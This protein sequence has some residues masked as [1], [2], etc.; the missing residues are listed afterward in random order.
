[1]KLVDVDIKQAGYDEK[2]ATIKNIQFSINKGE[3]VGLIGP[4]GAGKSTTIK[5]ILGLID[6]QGNITFPSKGDYAYIPEQP[7]FYDKLTL[8][9]HLDLAAAVMSMNDEMFFERAIYLLK[10]FKMEEVKHQLPN[11]FSK[12]MQQKVMLLIAFLIKPEVYIV[13]EPFIGLD[14]K[15]TKD[16]LNII[17]KEKQLGAGVLMSTHVLGT[18]EKVCDRFLLM[19][20]G[21]LIAEGTLKTIQNQCQLPNGSLFDCY[22]FLAEDEDNDRT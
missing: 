2:L 14:P 10:R 16:F 15:A 1:M 5:S 19:K 8:W 9:E 6:M 17:H 20:D 21:K 18:A 11:T 13:D 7:I 22:H 3:V 12:G 4:N